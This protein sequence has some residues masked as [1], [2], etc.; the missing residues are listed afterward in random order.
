MFRKDK[1][2]T[3]RGEMEAILRESPVIRIGLTDNGFPY[4]V[5][6]NFALREGG[7]FL[8]SAPKGMKMEMLRRNPRVCFETDIGHEAIPGENACTWGFGYRCVIGFGKVH[9]IEDQEEKRK[10]LQLITERYSGN[11]S[12][13]I[14]LDRVRRVAVI[15]IDIESMTGKRSG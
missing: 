9:F 4:V 14:P 6:M 13:D 12:G 5:P 1:E 3:D 8:H 10:A 2:I 15:R 11:A 7:I